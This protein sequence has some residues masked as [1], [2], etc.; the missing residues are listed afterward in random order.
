M[1]IEDPVEYEVPTINQVQ[2][3]DKI[4]RSFEAVLR[5]VLRQDPDVVLVGEIRD[6]ETARIATQ[7]AMTGHLV[8]TTLHTGDAIQATTRLIDM[9]VERF[10]VAPALI[11]VL[12]QRLVRRICEMCK[13]D[14]APDPDYLRQFFRWREGYPLPPLYRGEGCEHCGKTGFYGRVA[15]HEFLAVTPRLRDALMRGL[16]YDALREIAL[17]DGF[18]EM[19]YDGLKKALRG[20]TTIDEVMNATFSEQQQ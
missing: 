16:R 2:V 15:I 18:K 12:S 7:A 11:G 9:G 13:T 20:L 14:Y 4:G 17:A 1:T 10:M 6:P 19:R 5:S 3:D 8:L